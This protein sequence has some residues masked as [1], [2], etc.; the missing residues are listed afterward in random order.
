MSF[1]VF[2]SYYTIIFRF[3][4]IKKVILYVAKMSFCSLCEQFS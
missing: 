2:L 1:D 3:P 4:T